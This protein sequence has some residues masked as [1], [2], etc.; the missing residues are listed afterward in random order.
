MIPQKTRRALFTDL[1]N[2]AHENFKSGLLIVIRETLRE[3]T[4]LGVSGEVLSSNT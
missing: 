2:F 1:N 3:M 4:K